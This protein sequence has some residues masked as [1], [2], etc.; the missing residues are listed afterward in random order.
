MSG[1]CD[2]PHAHWMEALLV[3]GPAAAPPEALAA[4]RACPRCA[5]ELAE[6]AGVQAAFAGAGR[7]RREALASAARDVGPADERTARGTLGR[8]QARRRRSRWLVAGLA[9]A[10]LVALLQVARRSPGDGPPAREVQLSP[11]GVELVTPLGEVAGFGTF[12]WKDG[13]GAAASYRVGVSAFRDGA[14]IDVLEQVV[15][16]TELAVDEPVWRAWPARIEW[17]VDSRDRSGRVTASA[18]A[19]AWLA[20]R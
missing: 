4:I 1:D 6:L 3:D 18:A 10:A 11:H 8:H 15:E 16:A 5:R 13:D 20:P 14:W 7:L 19:E 9:A 17:R 2:Q 12:R